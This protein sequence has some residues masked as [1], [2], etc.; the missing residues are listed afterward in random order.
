MMIG[1]VKRLATAAAIAAAIAIGGAVASRA[2]DAPAGDPVNGKRLYLADGCFECHGR[3]GQGG[4]F[5]YLTPALAQIALP[6]ESFIAFLREAPN[7][8]PSFSAG[9]L[10]DKDAADIHAYLSSL[11]G[12]KAAKDIP[13]ILNE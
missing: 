10:S 13:A 2:E 6:V 9:V 5:N 8:M 11:P 7:D 4:R 12:P 1:S 3:A